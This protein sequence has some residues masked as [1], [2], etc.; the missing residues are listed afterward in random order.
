MIKTVSLDTARKLK[1]SGFRQDTEYSWA[2]SSSVM[3]SHLVHKSN[4]AACIVKDWFSAP[5]TD[6]LIEELPACIVKEQEPKKDVNC[7]LEIEK[8]YAD[9]YIVAYR[10]SQSELYEVINQSLPE[11]LASM[12]LWLKSQGLLTN[13]KKEK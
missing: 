6:E 7:W 9:E 11:S 13:G 2:E 1:E 3:D 5:T 10:H 4:F 12:Y 8:T